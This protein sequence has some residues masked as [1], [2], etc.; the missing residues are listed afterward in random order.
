MC[1]FTAYVNGR[2]KTFRREAANGKQF[3]SEEEKGSFDAGI[4]SQWSNNVHNVPFQGVSMNPSNEMI[5]QFLKFSVFHEGP[6]SGDSFVDK[7]NDRDNDVPRRKIREYMFNKNVQALG[8]F[9][10]QRD[11]AV[12]IHR[13]GCK[14]EP[15]HEM[16]LP[17]HMQISQIGGICKNLQSTAVIL[18]IFSLR[19]QSLPVYVVVDIAKDAPSP[20]VKSF[21]DYMYMSGGQY[22]GYGSLDSLSE[23]E[24]E[25]IMNNLRVFCNVVDSRQGTK[26]S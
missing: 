2:M 20:P 25:R 11:N 12:C 9:Y 26:S 8:L 14:K 4:H 17:E 15:E 5:E 22:A 16:Q 24:R 19:C 13:F 23:K 1:T 7:R 10:N 18:Q 21:I 3:T 6:Y